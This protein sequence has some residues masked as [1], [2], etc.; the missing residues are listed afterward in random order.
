[1][2]AR[3]NDELVKKV[4]PEL[5]L[6]D[7]QL[8]E[9]DSHIDA[10]TEIPHS[11]F[12]LGDRFDNN[13]DLYA[14]ALELYDFAL[15]GD[16]EAQFY[17]AKIM[18]YCESLDIPYTEIDSALTI[19]LHDW[20]RTRC[21]GFVNQNVEGLGSSD[22]WLELAAEGKYPQAIVVKLIKM[23]DLPRTSI[24]LNDIHLALS[25]KNSEVMNLMG[26]L[27]HPQ[28][29]KIANEAWRFLACD[30]GFDCSTQSKEIWRLWVGSA[31]SVQMATGQECKTDI[32]YITYSK[33][34]YTSAEFEQIMSK[35]AYLKGAIKSDRI[36]ELTFE[37]ILD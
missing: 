34:R 23:E 19:E 20:M 6:K 4:N 17:L 21:A 25:S 2:D 24:I 11:K 12:S 3:S 18:L 29:N 7:T 10:Y 28:K 1:M 13:D 35:V 32:D 27:G 8:N 14:L 5:K 15:N 30:Y 26:S 16:N 33:S 22:D 31:C 9:P 37:Q 36:N